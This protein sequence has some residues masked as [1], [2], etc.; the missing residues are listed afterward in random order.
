MY[1]LL[2]WDSEF[3]GFR[4]ASITEPNLDERN[5]S[6]LLRQLRQDRVELVYW[7]AASRLDDAIALGLGGSLVD[8]K[9]TFAMQL[10]DA[11]SPVLSGPPSLVPYAPG[12]PLADLESLSIQSGKYS[13]FSIDP[14]IGRDR[15]EQLYR[16]WIHRSVSKA[17]ARE[18]L[19]IEDGSHLV[20]MV[21]LAEVEGRGNIGLA[22]VSGACRGRG[23]GERLI[24]GAQA[25][26]QA[27][28]YQVAQVV[29]QGENA[30]ACSLYS[31]CGYKL[32]R[33]EFFYHFW[34]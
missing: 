21:T 2:P 11:S 5:L 15:F 24:R 4:I 20:G 26:F 17:I 10:A 12:M 9:T 33:Q 28:G 1:K 19:V 7:P 13:R 6:D 31:R 3:F 29:T 32:E 18:V 34:L 8:V 27:H 14:R 22:A 25:W 23:Y 30:A 16:L